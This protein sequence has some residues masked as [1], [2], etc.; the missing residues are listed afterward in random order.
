MHPIGHSTAAAFVASASIVSG[1]APLAFACRSM[2]LKSRS[3]FWIS[4]NFAGREPLSGKNSQ[5]NWQVVCVEAQRGPP[6][7]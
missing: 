2:T 5:E 7:A 4:S 6:F 3:R 1:D